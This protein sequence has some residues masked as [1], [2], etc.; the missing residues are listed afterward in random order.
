MA[1]D[2]VFAIKKIIKSF[3]IIEVSGLPPKHI[4]EYVLGEVIIPAV[5]H[6]QNL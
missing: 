4:F 3:M 1:D 2:P 5:S 6:T